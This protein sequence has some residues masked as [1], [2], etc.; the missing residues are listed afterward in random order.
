[1]KAAD[2]AI[3]SERDGREQYVQRDRQV[4]YH[5]DEFDDQRDDEVARRRCAA[6]DYPAGPAD[7]ARESGS[8][9][10][11]LQSVDSTLRDSRYRGDRN[12]PEPYGSARL[13]LVG[14]DPRGWHPQEPKPATRH[15][16]KGLPGLP[17]FA[18]WAW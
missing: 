11:A 3:A 1:V 15:A 18:G 10:E 8:H 2:H 7:R 17:I 16:L 12:R 6:T 13:G 5:R 14:I 4:R 9:L